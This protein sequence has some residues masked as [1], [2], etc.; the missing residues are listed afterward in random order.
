MYLDRR[1][2][3]EMLGVSISTLNRAATDVAFGE[4]AESAGLL[5]PMASC[6]G[7]VR[8]ALDDVRKALA[9]REVAAKAGRLRARKA[10]RGE[11]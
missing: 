5:P 9:T 6:I 10:A 8:Y 7:P 3:A 4:R 1:S 2:T 11:K